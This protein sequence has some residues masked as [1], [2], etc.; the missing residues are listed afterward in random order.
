MQS[1]IIPPTVIRIMIL[2]IALPYRQAHDFL[3]AIAEPIC[4]PV[5]IHEYRLTPYSLYAAV[6]VGL[7]T[8]DIVKYLSQ[9]STS[10]N[11]GTIHQ[12]S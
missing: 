11:A 9:V 7:Q 6:S 1:N 5:N 8:D 12:L 10:L 2:F 4:R 3:I